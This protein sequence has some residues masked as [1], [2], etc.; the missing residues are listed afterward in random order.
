MSGWSKWYRPWKAINRSDRQFR[1][2]R[3][4][5]S[6][7]LDAGLATGLAC[8]LVLGRTDL[9]FMP[10]DRAEPPEHECRPTGRGN[11]RIAND[12]TAPMA[13]LR[14]PKRAA[15]SAQGSNRSPLYAAGAAL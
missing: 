6:N 15:A 11:G 8:C 5:I 1:D 2:R 9:P 14:E 10:C 12:S 4:A 3:S 13:P 7:S